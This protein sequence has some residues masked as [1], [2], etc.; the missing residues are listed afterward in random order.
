VAA[1]L[2]L[3]FR[4]FQ[5]QDTL[6]VQAGVDVVQVYLGA[7]VDAQKEVWRQGCFSFFQAGG[8]QAVM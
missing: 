2:W 7:A 5:V 3:R 8:V 1:W 4:V 6:A